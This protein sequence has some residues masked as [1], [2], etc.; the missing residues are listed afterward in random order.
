MAAPPPPPGA[1]QAPMYVYTNPSQYQAAYYQPQMYVQVPPGGAMRPYTQPPQTYV[2][3]NL[4]PRYFL[5]PSGGGQQ[6]AYMVRGGMQAYYQPGMYYSQHPGAP[7]MV[8]RPAAAPGNMHAAPGAP[9][10]PGAPTQQQVSNGPEAA[11]RPGPMQAC[12]ATGAPTYHHPNAGHAPPSNGMHASSA[13]GVGPPPNA[14]PAWGAPASNSAYGSHD[15]TSYYGTPPPTAPAIAPSAGTNMHAKVEAATVPPSHA[16]SGFQPFSGDTTQP[17]DASGDRGGVAMTKMLLDAANYH[18][19]EGKALDGTSEG[20]ASQAGASHDG[21]TDE[22]GNQSKH[23]DGPV[24]ARDG[25][26]ASKVNRLHA[27]GQSSGHGASRPPMHGKRPH[28]ARDSLGSAGGS[29]GELP[30]GAPRKS[31]K[32]ADDHKEA[33]G[34]SDSAEESLPCFCERR[35]VINPQ[36]KYRGVWVQCESCSRW[37]HGEC[38]RL[39]RKEVRSPTRKPASSPATPATRC[40]PSQ[41]LPA[42]WPRWAW[43]TS[44][45]PPTLPLP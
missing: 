13:P 2:Q 10:A 4:A 5:V 30:T 7:N 14:A 38:A 29:H 20:G 22:Q 32:S 6:Q 39:T 41:A 25:G 34:G 26:A 24:S 35:L 45:S 36:P 3:N 16:P 31:F 42:A 18:E 23:V 28:S 43:P 9:G 1:G 19:S 27:H 12:G 17:S 21:H 40:C 44:L 33:E 15:G 37:C 8:M 11:H